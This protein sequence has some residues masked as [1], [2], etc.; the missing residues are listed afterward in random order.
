M[1]FKIK[2]LLAAFLVVSSGL[3]LPQRNALLSPGGKTHYT[4]SNQNPREAFKSNLGKSASKSTQNVFSNLTTADTLSFTKQVRNFNTSFAVEGEDILA[5][6]FVCPQD[7]KIKACGLD[8]GDNPMGSRAELKI[9][10]IKKEWTEEK[11]KNAGA[12]NLGYWISGSNMNKIYPYSNDIAVDKKWI[13]GSPGGANPIGDDLWSDNGKGAPIVPEADGNPGTYQ[14][15]EMNLLN[16]EPILKKGEIFAVCLKNIELK[17]TSNTFGVLATNET[18][19]GV[20]KFYAKGRTSGDISTAGWWKR[21]FLLNIAVAIEITGD[22]A[23]VISDVDEL[24]TTLS[25]KPFT[26]TA[27]ITDQNPSGGLSGVGSAALQYFLNKDTTWKEVVMTKTTGDTYQGTL[28]GQQPNTRVTYRVKAVDVNSNQAISDKNY[29]YLIFGPTP[30]V[31]SLLVFNGMDYKKLNQNPLNQYFLINDSQTSYQWP[32]DVWAYGQ[33]TDE[34]VNS[35]KNIFEISN[36]DNSGSDIIYNDEVIKKWLNGNG[37]RNYALAG[38]EWLGTRYGFIDKDFVTGSFEYDVLGI[39]HSYNDVIDTVNHYKPS[40]LFAVKGSVLADNLFSKF[41]AWG[42][43]SLQ[44]DPYYELGKVENWIDGFD[45]VAGQQTDM[46]VETK[47]IAGKKTVKNISCLTHRVLSG[48]NKIAFFSYDPLAVNT[49]SPSSNPKYFRFGTS[50]SAP[51]I[52]VLQW[53]SVLVSV[54]ETEELALNYSLSQNYPN[55]FNPSTTIKYTIPVVETKHASSLHVSLKIYDLLGR[56]VVT[57]VNEEKQPG[58]Y[59]VKF[60]SDSIRAT[61]LSSG[62]YFYTLQTN[63]F[64]QTKKMVLMK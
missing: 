28:P 38:Q 54:K 24:P 55:P 61:S 7:L 48:G 31:N 25:T 9:V 30:G 13:A 33:L 59:E 62:V 44:Y 58:N 34:V 19:Y 42:T 5:A 56:E 6:W 50:I 2:L 16:N 27:K 12:E 47:M 3:V 63:N 39:T 41:S 64:V 43:D 32:H 35:Y 8:A 52:R 40:R 60:N 53:F 23:P 14:W 46:Q 17:E 29:S 37:T 45:V 11:L 49:K 4:L 10:K 1:I 21:E 18:G 15:I 36:S 20:F 51:Q 57:L 22:E 26:V